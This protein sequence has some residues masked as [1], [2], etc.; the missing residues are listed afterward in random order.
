MTDHMRSCST[1]CGWWIEEASGC[2]HICLVRT[3]STTGPTVRQRR[4]TDQATCSPRHSVHQ[5]HASIGTTLLL[6]AQC[7][8]LVLVSV[9]ELELASYSNTFLHSPLHCS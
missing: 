3:E 4:K 7:M 1:C 2:S 5:V 9:R 6:V 8:W